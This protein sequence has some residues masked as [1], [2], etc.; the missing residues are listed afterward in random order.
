[1]KLLTRLL[2]WL[3]L[4]IA[5]PALAETKVVHVGADN[6][7]NSGNTFTAAYDAI[8]TDFY[9]VQ[10]TNWGVDQAQTNIASILNCNGNC[11]APEIVTVD[12]GMYDAGSGSYADAAAWVND[13]YSLFASIRAGAPG[14]KI[15]VFTLGPRTG[16]TTYTNRRQ[17]INDTLRLDEGNGTGADYI[18]DIAANPTLSSTTATSNTNIY[19]NEASITHYVLCTSACGTT[20]FAA[21]GQS[22]CRNTATTGTKGHDY[23]F[24]QY[25]CAMESIIAAKRPWTVYEQPVAYSGTAVVPSTDPPAYTLA[26]LPDI[27]SG[28]TTSSWILGTGISALTIP[29]GGERKFRTVLNEMKVGRFDTLRAPNQSINGHCHLFFGN[30]SVTGSSTYKSLRNDQSAGVSGAAG[31]PL[32]LTGYWNPCLTVANAL[33][34]GVTRVKKTNYMILYYV[35]WNVNVPMWDRPRGYAEI[36][37]TNMDDPNDVADKAELNGNVSWIGNGWQASN[38][39]GV[40]WF[41]EE[42]GE[43]QSFLANA[44]GSDAFTTSHGVNGTCPSTS[45]I[46][47]TVAGRGCWD[48]VNLRSTSG[49]GHIRN[50]VRGG[51][52]QPRCADNWYGVPEVIEKLVY[53][54][55]TAGDL[56]SARLDSDDPASAAS[57]ALGGAAMRNGESFH[58]DWFG[59][60]D[61]PTMQTWM[62]FCVASKSTSTDSF[63]PHE[64]DSSTI[65]A[66]QRLLGGITGENAPDGSRTPQVVL[67]NNYNGDIAS[68]WWDL[69]ATSA[70]T[71]GKRGRARL[72]KH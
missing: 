64:C 12:L 22:I 21:S 30:G 15:A 23:L 4:A 13:L 20:T 17:T 9:V 11:A 45:P 44:D 46:F 33:G 69:P 51:N 48:G 43:H 66:T 70:S 39:T 54:Y 68:E 62:H 53:S 49:Y 14:V 72:K 5:A 32:N 2:L 18:I 6:S 10:G 50:T 31:G 25:A 38:T 24:R 58:G 71:S 28:F 8:H 7:V 67:S 1:M 59:A 60:W 55:V 41:C 63:T 52:G 3:S 40:G 65:S 42:S 19:Q 35:S 61:Y 29:P 57:I 36:L 37:G 34:D 27:A 56:R 47:A 26:Q 16:D